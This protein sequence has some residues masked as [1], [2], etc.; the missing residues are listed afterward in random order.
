LHI[1]IYAARDLDTNFPYKGEIDYTDNN[2]NKG[3]GTIEVRGILPNSDQLLSDGNNARVRI[4]V[5]DPY[6]V[7]LVTERAIGNDQ[8]K[9][10]VYVVNEQN[11]VVRRDVKLGRHIEHLLVIEEGI[12]L[13]EALRRAE[14]LEQPTGM[15]VIAKGVQPGDWIIVNG[16]QRVRD[17]MKVDPQQGPMPGD[18]A[19]NKPT[20]KS[21]TAK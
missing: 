3:T 21:Q 13:E 15:Q 9:K 8:G 7:L 20:P 16:I 18:L 2:V 11:K 17:G 14:Q 6:K 19:A 10:Y 5:G 4:P 1:P 12:P